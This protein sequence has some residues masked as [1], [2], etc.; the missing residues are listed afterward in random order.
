MANFGVFQSQ[1]STRDRSIPAAIRKIE[2]GEGGQVASDDEAQTGMELFCFEVTKAI[3][4]TAV[5][6]SR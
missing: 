1:A 5:A 3:V 4:G 6:V 2:P